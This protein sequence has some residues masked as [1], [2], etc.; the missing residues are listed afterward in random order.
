MAE[1]LF[2]Q[3]MNHLG[4]QSP[5]FV[6]GRN[7]GRAFRFKMPIHVVDPTVLEWVANCLDWAKHRRRKAA[8]KTHM[9]LNRQSLRPNFVIIDTAGEHDN[10]RARELC[11]GVKRGEIVLFD[12][13]YVDFGHLRDLDQR[14]V[15]W[16]TRAKDNMAYEVVK[17][18]PPSKDQKILNCHIF[19]SVKPNR[20]PGN[21]LMYHDQPTPWRFQF[22]LRQTP[23]PALLS[24]QLVQR[25]FQPIFPASGPPRFGRRGC[26]SPRSPDGCQ[27]EPLN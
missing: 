16:V 8:A 7:R 27:H 15:S 22:S 17:I 24:R 23:D 3:V 10:Q 6:A 4:E 14:G 26:S 19:K 9:R 13:G 25:S 11:A 1:Q 21:H 12:K 20:N 5:G 18:M 2:W